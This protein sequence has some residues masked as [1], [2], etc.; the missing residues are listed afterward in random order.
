MP[1]LRSLSVAAVFALL[2]GC[3]TTTSPEEAAQLA[4]AKQEIFSLYYVEMLDLATAKQIIK[5]CPWLALDQR[6]EGNF[7][8]KVTADMER[9]GLKKTNLVALFGQTDVQRKIQNDSLAWIQR[10]NVLVVDQDSICKAG[11]TEIAEKTGI[12]RFIY[13]PSRP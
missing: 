6:E 3:Q 1:F 5:R 8:A 4:A 10:R 11:R 9:L 2:A 7:N 12:G 13:A